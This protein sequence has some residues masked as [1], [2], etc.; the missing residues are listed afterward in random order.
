M[1]IKRFNV[2]Y[3]EEY[4]DKSGEEKSYYHTVGQVVFFKRDDGSESGILKLPL[5]GR[6]FQIYPE[7]KQGEK[8][9]QREEKPKVTD[10]PVEYPTDKIDPDDIP[11]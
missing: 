5:L 9:I 10:D 3:R 2:K 8:V 1:D 6:E 4:K 11:F 7:E